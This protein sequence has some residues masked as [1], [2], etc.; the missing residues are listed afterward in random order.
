MPPIAPAPGNIE[1]LRTFA[2]DPYMHDPKLLR[3]LA[4]VAVP[5]LVIWGESD[6]IATPAYGRAYAAALPNARFELVR[7]AGHLP[8]IEQPAATLAL[9]DAFAAGAR[10]S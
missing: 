8:Q 1:A 6:G 5:T 2:G 7:E 3:R 9:V 4:R 10:R